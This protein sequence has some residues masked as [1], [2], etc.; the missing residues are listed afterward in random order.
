MSQRSPC[1]YDNEKPVFC[2]TKLAWIETENSSSELL[3]TKIFLKKILRVKTLILLHHRNLFTL[4]ILK[5][6]KLPKRVTITLPLVCNLLILI[7]SVKEYLQNVTPNYF[8][9][10][11]NDTIVNSFHIRVGS[12][13]PVRLLDRNDRNV[14]D[15]RNVGTVERSYADR[16]LKDKG[17]TSRHMSLLAL[18]VRMIVRFYEDSDV[19]PN[20]CQE[21]NL[22]Q[23]INDR[24]KSHRKIYFLF[25]Y[26]LI[27][28]LKFHLSI[29]SIAKA[30]S[31]LDH[32]SIITSNHCH[33]IRHTSM[34]PSSLSFNPL[35]LR[36]RPLLVSLGM[37][38]L[39]AR[40][41]STFFF[42]EIKSNNINNNTCQMLKIYLLVAN[43]QIA[44]LLKNNILNLSVKLTHVSWMWLQIIRSGDV[45][46]NPGPL[47][48]TLITLNCRGLKRDHKFKQLMNRVQ[49]DHRSN[50]IVALQETHLNINNLN[51][52]WRGKHIFTESN[53]AKGGIITLL[54]DNI[55][56]REQVDI[57]NEAHIAV[58]E[59][60]E[61]KE[62]HDLIIVNLH[63]P[64]AHNQN[65]IEFFKKIKIELDK[66]T[67]KYTDAKIVMMGDYNTTFKQSERIGTSRTK[68]EI[69]IAKKIDSI[70]QDLALKDCWE[71]IIDNSMTWRHGDKMSRLD[72]IQW[73]KDMNLKT[74]YFGTDWS[75]TQSDHCAVIVK[76]GC[77]A[78]KKFDKIVRID[79]FFM[80][81]VLLKHKFLTEL[82]DKMEQVHE[83]SMN[84]HQK[85]EYLKMTIRSTALEIASNY[86]KERDLEMSNLKRD[87][88]FWQSSFENSADDSFKSFAMTKLDESICKR[89]NIL[90]NKGEF[91]C[92]RLKSKWYQEGEKGTKY[93]LN[94]QKAKGNKLE[95]DSLIKDNIIV[96]DPDE[97]NKMVEDFYKKLYERGDSKLGNLSKVNSFLQNMEKPNNT[98]IE[99]ITIPLTLSDLQTTLN[100]CKDSS[101]GPD[102]IPY[103][104][105]KLTWSYFGPILL[106]S[107]NYSVLTG[108]LTHSHEDSY[109]KLLPKEGKD[110]KLLKNW[111]PITLSNCDFKVITKTLANRL[112]KNL[113]EVISQSQTAYMKDR[114]ITD[115]LHI[116]QYAVEKCNE[117]DSQS[118][119]VSLD[120][121]KAFD[122]V[123]HW[124]IIEVL[125]YIGLDKFV[126]TFK[127]L[128]KN[129]KVSIHINNNIAGSY[130]IKNGVKQGDALSC[131]LFI[132]AI[133]PLLRNINNDNDIKGLNLAGVDIPKAVAYADDVACI[134]TPTQRNLQKLFDHYQVMSNVSG[135]NLNADKTEII[136]NVDDPPNVFKYNQINVTVLPCDQVKINGLFIGY[137]IDQVRRRNFEKI[138]LS[139]DKQFRMWSSR[140]LSLMGKIQIFKTF[141]L[142]QILFPCSTIMLS[143]SEDRQITNLIYQFIWTRS[144]D[145]NKAPDRI[146]R[147]I[148][149]QRVKSLGFGMIDYKE[150]ITS[151][152][153][154]NVI[155]LLNNSNHPLHRIIVSNINSS[156]VNIKNL[157]IIRPTIDVAINKI[158]VMWL[159]LIKQSNL[160]GIASKS[161]IEIVMNEY[162]GNLIYPKF[163]NKRTVLAHKHDQLREIN[164]LS[165]DHSIIAKMEKNLRSLLTLNAMNLEN[166]VKIDPKVR[167]TL[168]PIKDKL[169]NAASV[170]S[171]CIRLSLQ[172]SSKSSYK[173]I[174]D[175]DVDL[176][177]SLGHQI[178]K[179]T[180]VRSK[181]TILRAIH[182]DI[183]CGTRLMK[184]GMSDSDLCSRCNI[185]ETITHQLMECNYVRNIWDITKRI[186]G[187]KVSSLNQVLGHDPFHDKSTLTL[188]AEIIR[189]L[190]A[191]ERP[192]I[193]PLN[194]VMNSVKRLSIVEKGITKHQINNMLKELTKAT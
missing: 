49:T 112:S 19:K 71:G 188:H 127:L 168:I 141:G 190:L 132:L 167:Y 5:L 113:N 138:L 56:V 58:I 13:L 101:P 82:R 120:A 22:L 2:Y 123:E 165:S 157:N 53:G 80:S 194:L 61:Q 108:N 85:L 135:L 18:F 47:D 95:L 163:M 93:F 45:E 16:I 179:L 35:E 182:G 151:I 57:E 128:Y 1:L 155:R 69:V 44:T 146:K 99:N 40:V 178:S 12:H 122:S 60:L 48:V 89:D 43:D 42:N 121:E 8:I 152:R 38:I 193:N 180:N 88:V 51:Y 27:Y 102:G 124:Y 100:S 14:R 17:Q 52:T 6:V 181:T 106:D 31:S 63:S 191:I 33:S 107:W 97:I 177:T 76:L 110:P 83:T 160:E 21:F 104:L 116:L 68:S 169:K 29:V 105:I 7:T 15:E 84:P 114:Q 147:S 78:K 41:S 81:N 64:C 154:K 23:Q 28:R 11:T 161:L 20:Q 130:K 109:L 171:K 65:K 46:S 166:T 136:S 111:R 70:M 140:G 172:P 145:G 77:I 118:M 134:I 24:I 96:D 164:N 66:F 159:S 133:E 39:P 125:K 34:W 72:R 67:I 62:S 54:S 137:D 55:A 153:I 170:T 74:N 25:H 139:M 91:I 87:I 148:L 150:V 156:T 117:L 50:L 90:D 192:T 32:P 79:T 3:I 129:Q 189:Q 131:I 4:F 187:I 75:Y 173:M 149:T 92:N 37:K 59:I 126:A 175:P 186:T 10:K 158:R 115:N 26:H 9:S 144:M 86:K 73:S 185:Q 176:I 142:S 143:K 162:V 36:L 183:Y 174:S 119:I 103:S 98:N 30:R 184:F 94:M